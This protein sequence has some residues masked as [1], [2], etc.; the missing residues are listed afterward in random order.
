MCFNYAF[1]Y[2]CSCHEKRVCAAYSLFMWDSR[3]IR[4]LRCAML[5]FVS[6]TFLW[7]STSQLKCKYSVILKNVLAVS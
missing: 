5:E 3:N 2:T 4:G 1:S 6:G 7:R